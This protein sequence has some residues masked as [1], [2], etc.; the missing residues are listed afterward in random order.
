M[1]FTDHDYIL[2]EEAARILKVS[3]PRVNRLCRSGVLDGIQIGNRVF[4]ARQS[5]MA[6]KDSPARKKFLPKSLKKPRIRTKARS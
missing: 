3:L 2:S 4:P 1:L 6:Y 5:V